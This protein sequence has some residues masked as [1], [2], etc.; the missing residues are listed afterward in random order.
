VTLA[1]VSN[2][3]VYSQAQMDQVI[4][5]YIAQGYVLSNR[6]PNSATM[7]KKKEFSILWLVIGLILCLIPLIIYL[8]VYLLES[9][10]LVQIYLADPATAPALGPPPA[11]QLSPDGRWRWDGNQWVPVEAL[12]APPSAPQSPQPA[13]P[14]G[15]P[16]G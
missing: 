6:T 2:I 7:F 14:G 1:G 11:G 16:G 5:A 3:P 12:A 13:E 10:R 4:T 9:D 8:F 15:T